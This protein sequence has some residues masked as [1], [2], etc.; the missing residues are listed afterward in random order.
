MTEVD[1]AVKKSIDELAER[2]VRAYVDWDLYAHQFNDPWSEYRVAAHALMMY[3]T[4]LSKGVNLLN[5]VC[6]KEEREAARMAVAAA[7]EYRT[8]YDVEATISVTNQVFKIIY[9]SPLTAD[10]MDKIRREFYAS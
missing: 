3:G 6:T 8:S 1:P 5:W 10:E 9:W 4:V 2:F 7:V